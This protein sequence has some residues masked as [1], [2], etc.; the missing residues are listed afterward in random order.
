LRARSLGL[1]GDAS[2]DDII[3]RHIDESAN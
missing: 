3:R 1:H 2:V